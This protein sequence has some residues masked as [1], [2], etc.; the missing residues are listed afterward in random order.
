MMSD[1]EWDP[2]IYDQEIDAIDNFHYPS[3]DHEEYNFD[4][5][6]EYK[7]RTIATHLTTLEEEFYEACE[8]LAFDDQVDDLL[9]AIHPELVVD[10]Y[11]VHKADVSKSHP[12]FDLLRP[13][14]GWAL[15][16]DKISS[17]SS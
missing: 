9:D 5:Y 11:D 2:S 16:D 15:A 12:N 8:F 13:L 17:F 10:I 6:G 4:Q 3:D 1:L 14:F 7:H